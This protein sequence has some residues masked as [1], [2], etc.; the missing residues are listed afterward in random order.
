MTTASAED[1]ERIVREVMTQLAIGSN[2]GLA[3][4]AASVAA[5]EKPTSAAPSVNHGDV[6]V[7][8]RVVTLESVAGR[9]KGAKQ[10]LVAAGS[11]VTPSVCDELRRKGITLVRGSENKQLRQPRPNV[12][13]VVGRT[14]HDPV[15]SVQTLTQAGFEVHIE[16]LDCLIA[17]TDILAATVAKR[18]SLG[19]LWT[20]H[21]AAG[22]CLANRHA[23]VRAVLATNVAGTTAAV[24]AV[25]ANILVVDPT[26][27]TP[28]E[29]KQ[30]LR[31]FCLGGIRE[32][33]E[34]LKEKLM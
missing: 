32:C 21:T 17:S 12:L 16:K 26:I 25:G 20:R 30:I 11:L 18:Q 2:R 4:T 9:L 24:A 22:L 28:Y 10:L 8:C 15:A 6:F 34:A 31:N 19:L 1:I 33:P 23:G 7:D 29:K 13:L 14:G 5:P 27:G 3:S